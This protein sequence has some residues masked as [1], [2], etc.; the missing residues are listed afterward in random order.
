MALAPSRQPVRLP[1]LHLHHNY[2]H[3]PLKSL[4]S[5]FE[6]TKVPLCFLYRRN[7]SSPLG[8]VSLEPFYFFNFKVGRSCSFLRWGDGWLIWSTNT[9]PLVISL[10]FF[11]NCI[12]LSCKP[13]VPARSFEEILCPTQMRL[14]SQA[15]VGVCSAVLEAFFYKPCPAEIPGGSFFSEKLTFSSCL[16]SSWL[17][18]QGSWGNRSP[19]RHGS[20][21]TQSL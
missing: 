6:A 8:R 13:N 14:S 16:S 7:D 15:F 1:C 11:S 20:S 10:S 17:A 18:L 19:T 9:P 21:Q 12:V 4:N 3:P 5:G 2:H